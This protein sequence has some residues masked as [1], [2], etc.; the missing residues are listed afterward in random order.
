MRPPPPSSRPEDGAT[1]PSAAAPSAPAALEALYQEHI[2]D[3]FRHPQGKGTIPCPDATG[4]ASNPLCGE[5]VTVT[6]T[7]DRT[8]PEVRVGDLRFQSDGCSITQASASMMTEL[9]RHRTPEEIDALA[10]GIRALAS[11]DPAAARDETLGPALALGAVARV[12]ARLACA[13]LGWEAL[14][15]ALGR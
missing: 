13:M 15:K 3:R 7:L 11:G 1:P 6:V 5:D 2:L 10:A 4:T 14:G 9:A 12:P 8:G